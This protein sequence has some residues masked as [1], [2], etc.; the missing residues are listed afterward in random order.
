MNIRGMGSD[1][2]SQQQNVLDLFMAAR[3]AG[4]DD[5][6]RFTEGD[7]R[8]FNEFLMAMGIDP[9]TVHR[10]ELFK[11]LANGTFAQ[12][13]EQGLINALDFMESQVD[14]IARALGMGAETIMQALQ[15][16]GIDPMSD[17]ND[18]AAAGLITLLN[19]P[20]I[21]RSRLVLPDFSTSQAGVANRFNSASDIL[22]TLI[23]ETNAGVFDDATISD[24]VSRFAAAEIASGM[25]A[26]VAGLS[27]L[28][29]I[30]EKV[31]SGELDPSVL[32][33]F[34]IRDQEMFIF[35]QLE[36]QYGLGEGGAE[37]LYQSYSD[38]GF[39]VERVSGEIQ[40]ISTERER[41]RGGLIGGDIGAFAEVA[42]EGGFR[43][44]LA[45]IGAQ[46]MGGGLSGGMKYA[47]LLGAGAT[48]NFDAV[49]KLLD[50]NYEGGAKQATIDFMSQS[51]DIQGAQTGILQQIAEN[52]GNA[53]AFNITGETSESNL[54]SGQVIFTI[55]SIPGESADSGQNSGGPVRTG[56]QS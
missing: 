12:D 2:F 56:R 52:T 11:K 7:T 1:V 20:V 44:F 29:E 32:S 28:Q 51:G 49:G 38:G 4:M 45:G 8:Q 3:S 53:V 16:L 47:R 31:R 15:A 24:F 46:G 43:Q 9:T 40:K 37:R 35:N 34:G 42:G 19:S 26:D 30:R 6:G 41:L 50:E 18:T 48:G 23:G 36:Q 13:M 55:E 27:G 25:S 21:D 22:N 14:N 54:T 17:F 10:D 5:E 33:K 39:S